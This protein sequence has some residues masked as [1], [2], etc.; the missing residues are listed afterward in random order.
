MKNVDEF[1]AQQS[2]NLIPVTA[3]T[4]AEFEQLIAKASDSEKEQAQQSGFKAAYGKTLIIRNTRGKVSRVY[5][6][7]GSEFDAKAFGA[8]AKAVP[9]GEYKISNRLN[10]QN[11]ENACLFF[12]LGAYVFDKYTAKTVQDVKLF[13]PETID[14]SAIIATAKAIFMGRN[15]INTPTNDLGTK[16]LG[17]KAKEIASK[18]G[19]EIEII[20]GDALLDENYPLIHAVGRAGSEAPRLAILHKTKEGAPKVGLVGKG[21]VFDSGGLDL[22]G[23]ASMGLMKKDMGGSA[24]ALTAFSIMCELDLPIDL[25]CYIPMVE[26]SVSSNS[27]R[28]GDIIKSR[29]G[30]TV[31]IDNTDAEGRLILADALT[32][33]S[34]DSNE[35]IF[36]FA[37]LTG[38]ARVALG[39]D[40]PPFY[41]KSDKLASEIKAASS[42]VQDPLWQ[43]PLWD[44]YIEYFDTPNADLKNS[45]GSFAGSITAALF[46]QKFVNAPEWV[47]FDVYCWNPSEKPARPVGADIQAVRTV[48]ETVKNRFCGS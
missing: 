41:T 39:P 45:G 6:G 1:I 4:L 14:A 24:C 29:Q 7:T 19:A 44:T 23:S 28:P 47:H 10:R 31:E 18:Y 48:V 26:N 11:T 40:L 35:V 9:A 43:M 37:T 17:A 3:V 30:I 34:E 21:V 25:R 27:M 8:I 22:K 42:K 20:K 12:L 2:N 16:A 13:F 32:R 36:D 15:L 5:L 38:A 46:L 33:A